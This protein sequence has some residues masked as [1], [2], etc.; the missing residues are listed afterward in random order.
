V[1]VFLLVRA[2]IL[3]QQVSYNPCLWS[4]HQK[5]RIKSGRRSI[6]FSRGRI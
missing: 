5:N 3:F 4:Q 6:E 1:F 2:A